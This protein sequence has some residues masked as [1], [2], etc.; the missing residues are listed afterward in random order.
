MII[1]G[2]GPG[3]VAHKKALESYIKLA[4]PYVIALNTQESIDGDLINI[5]AACHPV[6]LMA[7]YNV[8]VSLPQPLVTPI[9]MLGDKIREIFKEKEIKDFGIKFEVDTFEF[10]ENYCVVPAALVIAYALSIA[11]SGNAR[12]ILLAGFDGYSSDDKRN[13]EM[14]DLLNA[15]TNSEGAKP[16]VAITPTRYQIEKASVYQMIGEYLK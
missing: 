6:R 13:M 11:S 1:L 5:R 3:V 14:T 4:K 16:I 10:K 7:D 15:F 8:H 2:T 9:S 12:R